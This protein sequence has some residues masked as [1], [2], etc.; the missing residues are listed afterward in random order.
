MSAKTTRILKEA[1]SLLWPW[2]TVIIAGALRLV[3]QSDSALLRGSALQG[4]HPLIEAISFLGFFVGIP[5]LATLSLGNEFQHRTL[6]LLLSQPVSRMEIWSEKLIVTIVAVLSAALVFRYGQQ[7]TFPQDPELWV[8]GGALIIAMISSATF[9][10]LVARSTMGGL[11]LNAVS[12]SIPLVWHLRREGIA[13]T[14]TTRSVAVFAVLSYAGV[15]LWLGRRAL[16]QFQVTGGLAGDDLLMAGPKMMPRAVAEWLRCRSTSPLLNLIRKELRLLRPVWLISLLAVPAWICLPVLGFT[17]ER[18][19][20]LAVLMLAAFTPLIA[21]LAGTMSLGE[22]RTSGTHSWH[23]TLPVPARRQWL[24]KLVTAMF[25]GLVC[26]GLLP[27]S[28]LM[29]DRFIFGSTLMSVNLDA[30]M[31]WLLGVL[32]L[33][34]ASFWC[35]CMVNGTVSAALAVFPALIA[36]L[37]AGGLGEWV[38][39]RLVRSGGRDFIV[40]NFGLFANFRFTKAVSNINLLAIVVPSKLLLL[41]L[42]LPTLV[43]AVIQSG[44]LFRKQLQDRPLF[45]VRRLLPLAITA[46]LCSFLLAAFFAFVANAQQQMWGMFREIHEAIENT[47]PGAGNLDAAHPLQLSLEDLNKAAPLSERTQRWLRNARISVAPD[48]PHLGGRYCCPGNSRGIHFAPNQAYSW[49]LATIHLP[50]GSDCTVSFQAGG[51]YGILGGV[52]R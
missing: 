21:V 8:V 3:E 46:F 15:M 28:L 40:S 52:C 5:L 43:F 44:R 42:L 19:S 36:L 18:G 30:G 34:F 22:E 32:L 27:I 20:A 4:I 7:S 16:A 23:L 49:Y 13:E 45:V 33:S 31:T 11:A 14:M 25:T 48:K 39:N 26:A 1:G 50:S 47:Q 24:I 38:A 37:L 2:C 17:V 29:A 12:C 6:Q 51:G 10:T 9:W 35:A 41:L